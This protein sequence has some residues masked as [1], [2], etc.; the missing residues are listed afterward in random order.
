MP[1]RYICDVLEEMRK[2]Y[3]TRNFSYLPGLIE[4]AQTMANRMEA[5]LGEKRDLARWHEKVKKEEKEYERLLEKANK[6]RQKVGEEKKV[7]TK[8]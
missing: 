7:K 5:S 2:A 6:L 1:N 4:E 3:K 8:Y